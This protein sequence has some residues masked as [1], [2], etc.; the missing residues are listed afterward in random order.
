MPSTFLPFQAGFAMLEVGSVSLKNTKSILLKNTFD[1]SIGAICWWLVGYA[2]AFS[3]KDWWGD[4]DGSE[5]SANFAGDRGFASVGLKREDDAM[6]LFQWGFVMT[7]TTIVSG[8]VAERI[9]FTCA[10]QS[11]HNAHISAPRT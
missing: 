6:W 1:V 11:A 4:T 5:L 3:G 7:A 8:A 9:T 10:S 2:I